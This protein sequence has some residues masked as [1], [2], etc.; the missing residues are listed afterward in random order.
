MHTGRCGNTRGQKCRARGSG[1]EAKIQEFLYR[2]KT[3]V[4]HQLYDYTCNNLSQRNSDESCMELFGSRTGK[5]LNR[6]TTKDSCTRNIT[7]NT[8]STVVEI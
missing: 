1:K 7:P 5:T 2:Y 8:E 3:N 6:F 4:E